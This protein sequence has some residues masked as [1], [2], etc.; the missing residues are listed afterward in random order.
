MYTQ[1]FRDQS[2]FDS[3]NLLPLSFSR[4]KTSLVNVMID[5]KRSAISEWI[6][7]LGLPSAIGWLGSTYATVV[8]LM[9]PQLSLPSLSGLPRFQAVVLIA[10]GAA[11]AYGITWSLAERLV[12]HSNYESGG[13]ESL[14][15]GWAAVIQSTT[16]TVPLTVFPL[17]YGWLFHIQ[18]VQSGH[19]LASCC[20]ICVSALGHLVLYGVK[21]GFSGLRAK[22]APLNSIPSLWRGLGMEAVYAAVHFIS[23]VMAYLLVLR[24]YSDRSVTGIAL[25]TLI[26]ALMWLFGVTT[27]ILLK[28]PDS[29]ADKTTVGLRGVI[30]GLMLLIALQGGMLM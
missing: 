9:R 28:Y 5:I 17:L 8:R 1:N 15:Q 2:G 20:A 21:G 29:L 25:S 6:T 23:I 4:L 3:D 12:F 18:V 13:H 16:M 26:S 19:L 14:P 24:M 11:A 10:L 22:I 30:N 7:I 27:F